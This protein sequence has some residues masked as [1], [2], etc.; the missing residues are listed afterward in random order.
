M[1]VL[2][3][4]NAPWMCTGY[5]TQ[6][7][8]I[9]RH[10]IE[11]GVELDLSVN[12]G[13]HQIQVNAPLWEGGPGVRV[14]P[15]GGDDAG[16]SVIEGHVAEA[17]PDYV[18]TL[19]D[20]IGFSSM[21]PGG[22]HG[23]GWGK[24]NFPWVPYAMVDDGPPLAGYH[25][26]SL[27]GAHS[28]MALTH[29]AIGQ[30]KSWSECPPG[31]YLPH[32]L[33]ENEFSPGDKTKARR[34]LGLPE[35]K[36]I[37]GFVGDW[38]GWPGRKGLLETVKAFSML[39]QAVGYD[40]LCLMVQSKPMIETPPLTL[41]QLRDSFG[42]PFDAWKQ[43]TTYHSMVGRPSSHMINIYRACDVVCL[44]S[45]AEAFG[46]TALEAEMC[47]TPTI[48]M[49]AHALAEV[50][51]GPWKLTPRGTLT[52]WKLSN[53]ANP[54]ADDVFDAL[55][56]TFAAG[57]EVL[58]GHGKAARNR[59]C[60]IYADS[61]VRG[62]WAAAVKALER[63]IKR[64]T[65]VYAK[66]TNWDADFPS[67]QEVT[68]IVPYVPLQETVGLEARVDQ[69]MVVDRLEKQGADVI[70]VEDGG[71]RGFPIMVNRAIAEIPA[72]RN[73]KWILVWND[74]AIPA[75]GMIQTLL[76]VAAEEGLSLAAPVIIR[77]N[78]D[79]EVQQTLSP[80]FGWEV[81][82][83]GVRSLTEP[84]TE[85]L[86]AKVLPLGGLI[87]QSLFLVRRDAWNFARGFDERY[88]PG[89][90]DDADFIRRLAA[91]GYKCGV[92]TEAK[93]IH[94]TSST[95]EALYDRTELDRILTRNR[96]HYDWKFGG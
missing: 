95:F 65:A 76:R 17:K 26:D 5:G 59:A 89:Y 94:A 40:E 9:A 31:F 42:I 71:C 77:G 21:A 61:V 34:A 75:D 73:P 27:R 39:G 32:S 6:A 15:A 50:C 54:D 78:A 38:E 16:T 7:R 48:V 3:H 30:L 14:L 36:F 91:S 70:L 69:K 88:A 68:A 10:L 25:K 96:I 66:R 35:T 46:L 43:E 19:Y 85:D 44:P 4:S 53:W 41:V 64:P 86:A 23:P 18:M 55:K 57:R 63:D 13:H 11:L 80:E 29:F 37:V 12:V 51:Y 8:K 93:C 90:Y 33:D 22:S 20:A 84:W 87:Y 49:N 24:F 60:I 81:F 83:G 72:G 67:H 82:V 1:K 2:L 45:R 62:H 74:D 79:L 52:S 58:A 92:V 28:V 47:G 56:E